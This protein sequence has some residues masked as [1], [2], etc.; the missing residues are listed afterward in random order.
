MA[1]H[2]LLLAVYWLICSRKAIVQTCEQVKCKSM[3]LA[4][5]VVHKLDRHARLLLADCLYVEPFASGTYQHKSGWSKCC[6]P[7]CYYKISPNW[8]TYNTLSMITNMLL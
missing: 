4:S 1:S 8:H 2:V 5:L 3:R 6:N 7:W